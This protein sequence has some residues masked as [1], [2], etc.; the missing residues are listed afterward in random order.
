MGRGRF[1]PGRAALLGPG[2]PGP[3]FPMGHTVDATMAHA[4]LSLNFTAFPDLPIHWTCTETSS[5]FSW[6]SKPLGPGLWPLRAA[7]LAPVLPCAS[8][9]SLSPS[10]LH[11]FVSL[12]EVLPP[13]VFACLLCFHLLGPSSD[14]AYPRGLCTHL[15]ACRNSA[16]SPLAL[17]KPLHRLFTHSVPL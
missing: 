3:V 14:R 11:V 8:A 13:P 1:L 16:S 9:S 12:A 10:W 17:S 6:C 15:L 4:G 5:G 2:A 7:P